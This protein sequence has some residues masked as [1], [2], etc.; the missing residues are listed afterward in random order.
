MAPKSFS[1][2]EF[3]L[4]DPGAFGGVFGGTTAA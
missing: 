4:S 1:F 2:F 3:I